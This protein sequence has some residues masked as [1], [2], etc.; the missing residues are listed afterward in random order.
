[1]PYLVLDLGMVDD[2]RE[3]GLYAGYLRCSWSPVDAARGRRGA[4]AAAAPAAARGG[5]LHLCVIL[6]TVR[7]VP[8]VQKGLDAS[9]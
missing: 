5:E 6:R 3:P 1:M 4:V 8:M 2:A 7:I 9:D